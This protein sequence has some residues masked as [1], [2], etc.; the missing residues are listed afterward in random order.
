MATIVVE[1]LAKGDYLPGCA[2][3]PREYGSAS[4]EGLP[5]VAAI[6]AAVFATLDRLDA[7]TKIGARFAGKRVLVKPN[8]VMVYDHFGTERPVSPETTDP[9]LLDALV[10]W[11]SARAK[12]IDIVESSGRGSPT[13]AAFATSGIDR[14]ARKRGCGLVALEE[15]PVD[16]Y[17]LPKAKVLREIL[18]PR[19]FSEVVRGEAAY[20]SVPKLKTNLY[21]GVTLGFKNAMGVIPYNLRQRHHHYSIE[22]KL[23]EMLY[24]FKPDMVLIDGVV[25]GEGECPAPVDP[26]DSRFVVA[27]DHAV[28]T[29]RVA[30]RMMGFDPSTIKLMNVADELGFG[31]PAGTKVIGDATPVPFR[32]A[33]TSLLSERVRSEFPS[34]KVL[35]G[36]DRDP[37]TMPKGP[38]FARAVESSCW[39]GCAATTRF[40]LALISAEGKRPMAP[41]VLVI[42][43]GIGGPGFAGAD[44]ARLWY[45]TDGK[46]WDEASILA[47]PGKKAVVGSCGK[48]LGAKVDYFVEGC[49]P[50][51]NAPHMVIHKILG[52]GCRVLSGR[53]RHLG[54]ILSGQVAQRGARRGFIKAGER[55][56]VPF[57]TSPE[58]AVPAGPGTNG[59]DPDWLP[60]PLPPT[61]KAE[62]KLLLAFEDDAAAASIRGV[63]EDRFVAKTFWR[64]QSLTTV[65]VTVAPFL[66]ALAGFA[67][68]GVATG[69][70]LAIWLA[71]EALH[72]AELPFSLRAMRRYRERTG[73]GRPAWQTFLLTLVMGYPCWVPWAMGIHDKTEG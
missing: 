72:V 50:L 73:R 10:L 44:G 37:P 57:E 59:G 70:W 63:F 56:D 8:L 66:V 6:R 26:V 23:V 7:E 2:A 39:G 68:L 64:S 69:T 20:V 47:L 51:A 60:W 12:S 35:V 19:I 34:L 14:L 62:R 33:D 1:R 42:G 71:I 25:G 32:P 43:P 9:R 24:L 30:T 17:L 27:G 28:E 38:D 40:G 18:V 55:L 3:L 45:D 46:A 58:P 49:M 48:S 61:E 5:E 41:G 16:R 31:D 54:A 65:V 13:R 29:D 36:I 4:W 52:T 22:R 15:T 21:T 67:G 11:L 53:N